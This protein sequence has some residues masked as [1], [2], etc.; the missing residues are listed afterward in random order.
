[1]RLSRAEIE[2]EFR[3]LCKRVGRQGVIGFSP[4]ED[5]RLMQV[6]RDYLAR[7]LNGLGPWAS[8]TAV[9]IGLLYH[10][11]EILAI[12]AGWVGRAP[13]NGSWNR[14]AHAYTEL[15]RLLDETCSGLVEKFGGVAEQATVEGFVGQ[16]KHVDEYFPVAVSHRAF[17]EAARM[18]WRGRHGLVVT[19]EA[20]PALRL[21]TVFVPQRLRGDN[22]NL[23][24]CGDCQA[25]LQAC[26]ILRQGE[27]YRE[28]CRRWI[29]A[30]D[31]KAEVCGICVR[32]C[33]EALRN[34]RPR[35]S[36]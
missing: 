11:P 26:S 30:L 4:V 5:A 8:I 14:Y 19:P 27:D 29:K 34:S 18:G 25:C 16:V 7:K 13:A 23:A 28:K 10:E 2:N 33:W 17:A 31:L 36:T 24:G 9:S 20:G 6:Q 32:I 22:R 1:M 15:N 3:L 12:P 35:K 21:A